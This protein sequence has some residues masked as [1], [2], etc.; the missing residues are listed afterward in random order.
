MKNHIMIFLLLLLPL[1]L[2]D[3]QKLINSSQPQEKPMAKK[4]LFILMPER[5]QDEEF[6]TPYDILKDANHHVDVAGLKSGVATGTM[7][8]V[9]TPNLLL[10]N[11]GEKELSTYD[12][13]VI[14]G[15]PASTTY[16]WNNDRIQNIIRYFH[17]NKKIVATICYACIAPAQTGI[18][19]EK[20]ATVF[21]T[22]EA[23]AHFTKHNVTFSSDGCVT[24]KE[25]KIIT[26]QGPSFA[27]SFGK[28][29]LDLLASE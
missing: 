1:S 21:P 12:A 27:K 13:L 23:K 4:I 14:P 15:G 9:F 17:E 8:H 29:I 16:L 2:V 5:Y 24:L 20:V 26:A 3:A 11:L 10:K 25:D 22:D 19:E 18:L 28:A 6:T 7:G